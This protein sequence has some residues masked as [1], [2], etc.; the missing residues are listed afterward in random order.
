MIRNEL[1]PV[2][3]LAGDQP[4][5]ADGVKRLGDKPVVIE[6]ACR[7]AKIEVAAKAEHQALVTGP[8]TT[9]PHAALS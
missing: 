3:R 8:M 6:F 9:I 5:H 7:G 2:D 1:I 4:T